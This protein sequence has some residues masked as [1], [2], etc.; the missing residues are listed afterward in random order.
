M[1]LN[2]LQVSKR[3][4]VLEVAEYNRGR[5]QHSLKYLLKYPV[6]SWFL[7]HAKRKRWH[8]EQ[9]STS[10]AGSSLFLDKVPWLW[11]VTCL[12]RQIKS[13]KG[14]DLWLYLST[15]STEVK[16]AL[17]FISWK[18]KASYVSEILPDWRFS[19]FY[20]NFYDCEILI[21]REVCLFSLL[22]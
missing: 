2:K 16:V 5:P 4:N 12:C 1:V 15:L 19:P 20:L 21:E 18:L 14:V 7:L 17:L 8:S 13:A 22:F 9:P 10:F 6:S 3:Q 11:L